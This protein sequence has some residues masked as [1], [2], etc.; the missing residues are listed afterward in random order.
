MQSVRR[1]RHLEHRRRIVSGG[2]ETGNGGTGFPDQPTDPGKG[3]IA[4]P[5]SEDGTGTQAQAV[6]DSRSPQVD[7]TP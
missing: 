1:H 5:I 6:E 2:P 4:G 3:G 7:R